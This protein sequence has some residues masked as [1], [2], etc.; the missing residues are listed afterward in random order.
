MTLQRPQ[1]FLDNFGDEKEKLKQMLPMK[2][3][4]NKI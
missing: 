3:A 2:Y 4:K 1:K